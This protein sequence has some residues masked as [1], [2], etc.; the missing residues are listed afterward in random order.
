MR[1][2]FRW[3]VPTIVSLSKLLTKLA[4]DIRRGLIEDTFRQSGLLHTAVVDR[5]DQETSV[6]NRSIANVCFVAEEL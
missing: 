2:Y 5:I 1:R 6:F 4:I 3:S